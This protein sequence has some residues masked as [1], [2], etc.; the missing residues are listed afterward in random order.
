MLQNTVCKTVHQYNKTRIAKEDMSK[1]QEIA[2]DYRRVKN[3]VYRHYGSIGGL[4]KIY[5][6]YTVFLSGS[7]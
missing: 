3:Y 7:V 6:G 5:P 2:E 4:G 1:L